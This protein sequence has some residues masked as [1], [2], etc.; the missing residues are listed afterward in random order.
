MKTIFYIP[1]LFTLLISCHTNTESELSDDSRTMARFSSYDYLEN[2]N[3]LDFEI[4]NLDELQNFDELLDKMAE[5]SCADKFIGLGFTNHDTIYKLTGFTKCPTSDVTSCYFRKNILRIKN[6]SLINLSGDWDK[7]VHIRNLEKEINQI[8]VVEHHFLYNKGI[9]KPALIHLY[10][11]SRYP[12][13]KTKEVLQE[14]VKQFKKINSEMGMDYFQ[15]DINFK[16]YSMLD[17]P[18]PPPPTDMEVK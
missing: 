13:S 2:E 18:P 7:L 12:I 8:S 16:G 3:R 10:I 9:L 5:L 17:I 1:I 14:I 4:I 15:Y 11:E 6:D